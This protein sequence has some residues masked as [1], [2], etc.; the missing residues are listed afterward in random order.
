MEDPIPCVDGSP[1][2]HPLFGWLHPLVDEAVDPAGVLAVLEGHGALG[3]VSGKATPV[4]VSREFVL[5]V[6]D[7]DRVACLRG[8]PELVPG[9][10]VADLA[11]AVVEATGLAVDLGS[12]LIALVPE[13][14]AGAG[15]PREVYGSPTAP[16][17]TSH[18]PVPDVVMCRIDE[19]AL[20]LLARRLGCALEVWPVP[21]PAAPDGVE[22]DPGGVVMLRPTE[23]TGQ[24]HLHRWGVDDLPVVA[25]TRMGPLRF[26][27]VLTEEGFLPGAFL[28]HIDPMLTA[29]SAGDA[30]TLVGGHREVVEAALSWFTNPHLA[31][32]AELRAL[33][34]AG[35]LAPGVD[36]MSVAEALQSPPDEFWS[37]RVLEA[38][39]A[40][41]VAADLHEGRIEPADGHRVEPASFSEAVAEKVA[42]VLPGPLGSLF[43]HR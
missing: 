1:T 21:V 37:R 34:A 18:E 2:L 11:R 31:P 28:S 3:A 39:R 25:L 17:W 10:V 16:V 26:V 43:R 30:T 9:P 4:G 7:D 41:T 5:F 27:A 40:P 15:S 8:G 33:H 14:V 36:P 23:P 12:V 29:V 24:L 20:P 13:P 42:D 6:D 19:M 38:L 35:G 32:D 22:P